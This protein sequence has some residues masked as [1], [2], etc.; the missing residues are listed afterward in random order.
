MGAGEREL[1]ERMSGEL[2]EAHLKHAEM[3]ARKS[4]IGKKKSERDHPRWSESWGESSG[5]WEQGFKSAKRKSSGGVSRL[6]EHTDAASCTC[7]ML[8]TVH[9]SDVFFTTKIN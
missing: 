8:P 4:L 6:R 2:S 7:K 1:E 5:D 3:M 9:F